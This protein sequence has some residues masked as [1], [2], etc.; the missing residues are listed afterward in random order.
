MVIHKREAKVKYKPSGVDGSNG[1]NRR[2]EV[3]P[4]IDEGV[5]RIGC[6]RA[7]GP[8]DERSESCFDKTCGS[9]TLEGGKAER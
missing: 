8:T 7:Q 6:P 5:L 2:R 4:E 1:M 9:P 3:Q